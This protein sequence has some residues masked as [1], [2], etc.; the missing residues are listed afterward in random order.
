MNQKCPK[1]P[2]IKGIIYLPKHDYK[3]CK[4]ITRFYA[5]KAILEQTNATNEQ[6]ESLLNDLNY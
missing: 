4:R 3:M 1:V 2:E 6:A 5:K